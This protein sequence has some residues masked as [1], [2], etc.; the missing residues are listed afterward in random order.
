MKSI[1]VTDVKMA[2]RVLYHG[3]LK[4]L[5]S[6]VIRR[7]CSDEEYYGLERDLKEPFEAPDA[8]IPVSI[9]PLRS[10]DI[11]LLLKP[12]ERCQR[13]MDLKEQIRRRSLI[14]SDISTCYVAVTLQGEPCYMQWLIGW[15]DNEAL[16]KYF[17]GGFPPLEKDEM[18][19][20]G[21]YTPAS[22][23]G[24][25][26]MPCVMAKLAE[27]GVA[28]GA[29]KVM[30]YVQKNNVAALKGCTRAGFFPFCVRTAQW[31]YFKR[32]LSFFPLLSSEMDR[33][34]KHLQP[35]SDAKPVPSPMETVD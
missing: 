25:G 33:A 17:G 3:D 11:S 6:E 31:R 13:R 19:L 24:L 35:I 23:R 27:M 8:L 30:T 2:L 22:Y 20:E 18:L 10:S 34:S 15:K 29:R 16:S 32:R 21:A 4:L 12:R 5:M 14:L 7:I 28:S 9:R 26:I 1:T